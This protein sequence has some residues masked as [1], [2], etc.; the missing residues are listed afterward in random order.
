MTYARSRCS[1]CGKSKPASQ[2]NRARSR[3]NGLDS[4]CTSCRAAYRCSLD[5][6]SAALL[7]DA[8]RRAAPKG[9]KFS[10]T[11]GWV[12]ERLRKWTC[13]ATGWLFVIE[14]GQG[15]H[16]FAPGID[17]INPKKGYTAANCR[18][19]ISAVNTIKG[20][21]RAHVAA[22]PHP[23]TRSGKWSADR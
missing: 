4:W 6:R 17:R 2:F 12:I 22:A 20:I 18:L 19:V 8:R 3:K 11:R 1:C 14:S 9:I 7:K 23:S 15:H 16:P 13:E 21:L 10:L 5:G